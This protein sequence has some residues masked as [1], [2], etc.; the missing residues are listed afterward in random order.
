[1]KSLKAQILE[2]YNADLHKRYNEYAEVA[3]GDVVELHEG[4]RYNVLKASTNFEDVSE[5]DT[6]GT[7]ASYRKNCFN[8]S[9]QTTWVAFKNEFGQDQVLPYGEDGVTKAGTSNY[10]PAHT[11]FCDSV[12]EAYNAKLVSEN[13]PYADKK[14]KEEGS[15]MIKEK[16]IKDEASLKAYA[17]ELADEAF[18]DKADQ[19]KIDSM[20]KNAIEKSDGDWGKAAGIVKISI[21]PN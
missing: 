12:M 3:E 7:C 13:C 19:K 1:M 15:H 10:K 2:A 11:S 9:K 18:G 20:V 16:D 8:E 14:A 5:F 21:V 17:K 4:T 6:D